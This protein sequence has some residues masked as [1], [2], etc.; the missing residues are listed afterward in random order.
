MS[1]SE[2]KRQA[3]ARAQQAGQICFAPPEEYEPV[4]YWMWLADVLGPACPHAGSVIDAFGDAR[5]VWEQ[6]DGETFRRV[7]GATAAQRALQPGR[8]PESYRALWQRCEKAGIRVLGFDDPD[9]PL[10]LAR[11]PDVPPVLYCTGDVRWLNEETAVGMVGSRLPT[12]YGR[13][14]AAVF[15]RG[16]AEAGAVVVS[17]LASGL[18]SESHRAAVQ[19]GK[20]TIGVLGVPIDQTYPAS[21]ISL[22]RDIEQCGCVVSEYAPGSQG[23]GR[24]GFVQR[25][26][27]IAA[28][29][30]AL[31]V[32]EAKERSGTMTTVAHAER[33]AR[34]VYAIPGSIFM[35]TCGGTNRLIQAGRAR[36]AVAPCDLLADLGLQPEEPPA[37][38]R[39]GKAKKAQLPDTE[40]SVLA[41][42][43]AQPQGVE[44]LAARS[45]LPTATL[46][47]ALMR[48]ELEGLVIALPG[49]R[50]VLF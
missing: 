39:A 28:L 38:R 14:A 29:G 7:A 5:T 40:R 8:T 20:P 27:L 1:E 22:R 25:N 18:D 17:G 24:A 48:L 43:G 35:D 9:Y 50:Y 11:I 21:N 37:P 47:G 3:A 4:L 30:R 10:A 15:G 49:K 19:A 6:C 13:T 46:L 41:C 34:P 42:V 23:V 36:A 33:Y 2:E 16:L 32:V 31:L 45:G 44:E 26:R 12:A